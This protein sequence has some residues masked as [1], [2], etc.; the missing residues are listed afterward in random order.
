MWWFLF[1]RHLP[2]MPRQREEWSSPL[3]W[4]CGWR[5][6]QRA[7]QKV[8]LLQKWKLPK[9]FRPKSDQPDTRRIL[10][11]ERNQLW[12]GTDFQVSVSRRRP[13]TRSGRSGWSRWIWNLCCYLNY[14]LHL[15]RIDRNGW[16]L[17][18][19][20]FG[21]SWYF[22]MWSNKTKLVTQDT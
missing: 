18:D 21:T 16:T 13:C 12:L 22:Q 8:R 9:L 1:I 11:R 5:G 17:N 3:G 4:R 7:E 10:Q 20:W 2:W 19:K 14:K 15:I 6:L